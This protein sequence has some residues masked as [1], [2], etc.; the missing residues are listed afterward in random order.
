MTTS[1]SVGQG[2]GLQRIFH[3]LLYN[4][5]TV[6]AII[7][8]IGSVSLALAASI[9][10]LSE[11]NI[12]QAIVVLLGLIG[13]S[14]LADKLV[15]GKALRK[16]LNGICSQLKAALDYTRQI[17]TRSLDHHITDVH[18]LPHLEE[19]LAG[20]RRVSVSGGSLYRLNEYQGL[21][22]QLAKNGCTLRFL[23]TD[24]DGTSVVE[25][26]SK[27][28]VY[29]SISVDGYRAQV[30]SSVV[31]F[32]RLASRFLLCE[33]R[34][35][36]LPPPYGLMIVEKENGTSTILVE[37]YP[38]RLPTRDRPMLFLD[39]QKDPRLHN[40]FSSQYQAMWDSE[41][42]KPIPI[43]DEFKGSD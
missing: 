35:Y 42:S 36:T 32:S 23:L 11:M 2:S 15:E 6:L 21:F 7:T 30:H 27:G 31:T 29:E 1:D 3:W 25:S 39:K 10:N 16:R 19:R 34:L 20:A 33:V 9:L 22:E 17:E 40:L 28:V 13:A 26:L 41:F 38:F 14:L 5:P 12:L 18:D 43:E 4:S 24:P 37:I 8:I